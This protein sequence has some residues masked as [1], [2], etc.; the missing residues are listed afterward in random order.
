MSSRVLRP[1]AS[2]A[3]PACVWLF[4]GAV[5]LFAAAS[6][7]PDG[8]HVTALWI[9]GP[10]FIAL[11]VFWLWLTATTRLTLDE[12]GF[13]YTR[14]GRSHRREW[15]EVQAVNWIAGGHQRFSHIE[16]TYRSAK[17]SFAF[18]SSREVIHDQIEGGFGIGGRKLADL[19]NETRRMH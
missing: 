2:D 9:A 4:I 6:L 3:V 16:I 5:C 7:D 12:T 10:L 11:G 18:W 13:T 8:W 15:E 17:P 19:V 1:S 14:G